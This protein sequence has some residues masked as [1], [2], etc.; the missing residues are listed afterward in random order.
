MGTDSGKG[1]LGVTAVLRKLLLNTPFHALLH[2]P[3]VLL[4]GL[5]PALCDP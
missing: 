1:L 5:V 3:G 2:A 4:G